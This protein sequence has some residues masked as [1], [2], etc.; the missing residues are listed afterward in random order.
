MTT[1]FLKNSFSLA[2]F[3]NKYDV[4]IP[5]NVIFEMFIW[6]FFNRSI[7]ASK[8]SAKQCRTFFSHLLPDKIDKNVLANVFISKFLKERFTIQKLSRVEKVPDTVLVSRQLN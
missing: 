7:I 3:S 2:F 6:H 8:I 4:T 1:Y 5:L